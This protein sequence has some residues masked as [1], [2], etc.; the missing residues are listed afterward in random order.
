[1][2]YEITIAT[3]RLRWQKRTYFLA[4]KVSGASHVF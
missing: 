2:T 4:G 1:M 3:S